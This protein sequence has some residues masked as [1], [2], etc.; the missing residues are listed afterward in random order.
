MKSVGFEA[1]WTAKKKSEPRPV[2]AMPLLMSGASKVARI[3]SCRAG[4]LEL[5]KAMS[6]GA[7][8]FSAAWVWIEKAI[9]RRAANQ[10]WIAVLRTVVRG[11][12]GVAVRTRWLLLARCIITLLVAGA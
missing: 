1:A 10:N 12:F 6:C 2:Q 9:V 4:L 3:A 5:A 7:V 8:D 11:V